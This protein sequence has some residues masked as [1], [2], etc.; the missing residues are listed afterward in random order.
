[1]NRI[2]YGLFFFALFPLWT[3]AINIAITI[4]D[5]PMEDTHIFSFQERMDRLIKTLEQN[6]CKTVFFLGGQSVKK[7]KNAPFYLP[8]LN[9]HGHFVANHTMTHTHLSSMPLTEF[10]SEIKQTES[11]LRP[12]TNMRKWFRYP[13]LDDG[14]ISSKGG[15]TKKAASARKILKKLGYVEGFVTINTFDWHINTRLQ[16]A[17]KQNKK[18]DYQ[19][20]KKL[21]LSLIK[22]WCAYFINSYKSSFRKEITHTL[23]LHSNDLNALYLQDIIKMIRECEWNIVSPEMAFKDTSWRKKIFNNQVSIGKPTTLSRKEIDRLLQKAHVFSN[24]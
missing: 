6:N 24:P 16:Q 19:A 22:E 10:E 3:N 23:L 18:I 1:M 4:D 17:I 11:I 12:Y 13:Y 14:D 20:L 9:Q 21:Y 2:L 5:F 8:Q 7:Q 15:S